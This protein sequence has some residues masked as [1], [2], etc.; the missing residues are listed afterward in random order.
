M[1]GP[2]T[3]QVVQDIVQQLEPALSPGFGNLLRVTKRVVSVY[4]FQDP[5]DILGHFPRTRLAQP[6]SQ[7]FPLLGTCAGEEMGQNEGLPS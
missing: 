4:Q 1:T 7:L 6:L 2:M 5:V 3:R